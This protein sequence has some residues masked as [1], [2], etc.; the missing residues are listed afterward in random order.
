MSTFSCTVT[1]DTI[2][3]LDDGINSTVVVPYTCAIPSP[4]DVHLPIFA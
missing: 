4:E 3:S 2:I 1:L